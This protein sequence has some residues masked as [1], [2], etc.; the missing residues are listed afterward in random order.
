[1]TDEQLPAWDDDPLEQWEPTAA[2]RA[3]ALELWQ[4]CVSDDPG[5]PALFNL[6]C[7]DVLAERDLPQILLAVLRHGRDSLI[8]C[9]GER[10]TR[11][12]LAADVASA[13]G[14]ALT[15]AQCPTPSDPRCSAPA[16]API[17]EVGLHSIGSQA[18]YRQPKKAL[19]SLTE[20]PCNPADLSDLQPMQ[21]EFYCRI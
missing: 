21:N 17:P 6:F 5:F 9:Q 10:L 4:R 13:R 15:E 2:Q 12:R 14:D 7:A 11:A 8:G 1:M 19:L 3:R 16:K 18:I 20:M